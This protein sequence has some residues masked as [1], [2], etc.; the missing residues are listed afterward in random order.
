MCLYKAFISP[1]VAQVVKDRND[2][3]LCN[4]AIVPEGYRCVRY[5]VEAQSEP[6]EY[7]DDDDM[8]DLLEEY[9]DY[10]FGEHKEMAPAFFREDDFIG[11]ERLERVR[12]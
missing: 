11:F 4:G 10:F 1:L 3:L 5:S 12:R 6:E 9:R 7:D 8:T 2:W